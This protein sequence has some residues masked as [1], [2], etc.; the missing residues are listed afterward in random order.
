MNLKTHRTWR[1]L[2]KLP[3]FWFQF[4]EGF[5]GMGLALERARKR[6]KRDHDYQLWLQR[7]E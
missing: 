2:S 4:I 1:F 3:D 6:V 7:N 5:Q